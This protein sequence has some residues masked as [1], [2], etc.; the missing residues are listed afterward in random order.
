[1]NQ[2]WPLKVIILLTL[3]L[4]LAFYQRTF[5]QFGIPKL[6]IFFLAIGLLF[7]AILVNY[8]K[9]LNFPKYLIWAFSLFI[10]VQTWQ[11]FR[12][13]NIT[14]GLFGAYGQ[15]ES[16]FVQLGFV[17]ICLASYLFIH[18]EASQRMIRSTILITVC[19]IGIYGIYQYLYG[20]LITKTQITRVKSFLGDPNALGAFLVL[21]L[22]VIIAELRIH[23]RKWQGFLIASCLFVGIVCLFLSFSRAAWLGFLIGLIPPTYQAVLLFLH[24]K[25]LGKKELFFLSVVLLIIICGMIS[26]QV[27]TYFQPVSHTDYTLQARVSSITQGNDSGRSLIWST[28]W[29]TFKTSPILGYGIGSFQISFH[30]FKAP[31]AMKFWNP[32][33]ALREVHNE[34]LHYLATQGIVGLLSYFGLLLALILTAKI[35]G[36]FTKRL[37]FE[38]TILWSAIIGYLFYVQFNYP[39]IHYSFLFWI[40]WGILL[41]FKVPPAATISGNKWRPF[42]IVIAILFMIIWGYFSI[43][44]FRAD[45]Y[46]RKA[47]YAARYHRYQLSISSYR[48]AISLTPWVFHYRYRFGIS[49]FKAAGWEAEHQNSAL[50]S[51]YLQ[52]AKTNQLYLVKT[53]PD[54][55][56]S[57]FL[58]GQIYET[59]GNF[60][61]A[62]RYYRQALRRYPL[63]YKISFRLAKVEW[64]LGNK[65]EFSKAFQAGSELDPTYMQEMLRQ[66]GLNK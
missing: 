35:S 28:A 62:D 22:P 20:D 14:A 41:S 49:L 46:Y 25:S 53:N 36:L 43:N 21:T 4:P 66:E 24:Q 7:L 51:Q 17:I 38:E 23:F 26:G 34:T 12:L 57:L 9:L 31:A 54:H 59:L 19:F 16:L 55:Y 11:T 33:R 52:L 50:A 64:L 1:L 40:Y 48:R 42:V 32:E 29:K 18:D 2:N 13:Y 3:L 44:I 39:L 15:S 5:D 30:H 63:N 27:L 45:L 61:T 58:L 60:A 37:P 10:F 65:A 8:K 6:T 47:F 56:E